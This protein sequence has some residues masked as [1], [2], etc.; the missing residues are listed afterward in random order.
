MDAVEKE[1]N[2]YEALMGIL[3]RHVQEYDMTHAQVLGVLELTKQN[4]IE[5]NKQQEEE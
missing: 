1:T 2:L 5:N 4:I 3:I